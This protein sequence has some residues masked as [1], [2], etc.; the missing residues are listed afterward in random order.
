MKKR[1]KVEKLAKRL[2]T[3][4]QN[5]AKRQDDIRHADK[6]ADLAENIKQYDRVL[7]RFI[8]RNFTK[9]KVIY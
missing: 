1:T 4:Y 9:K 8:L 6:Y 3:V 2:H 7:A 5:E